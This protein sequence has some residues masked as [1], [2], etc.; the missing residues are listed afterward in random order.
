MQ[1]KKASPSPLRGLTNWLR[2]GKKPPDGESKPTP[3]HLGEDANFKWDP[4]KK[5][6]IFEGE[7][8]EE[9]KPL[10]PPPKALS[11]I[12]TP[13]KNEQPI[14]S[15]MRPSGNILLLRKKTVS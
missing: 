14:N 11:T 8:E 13:I 5:K 12:Q 1:A 3:M 2:G 7:P 15:L 6:Y 4:I 9:E 10:E